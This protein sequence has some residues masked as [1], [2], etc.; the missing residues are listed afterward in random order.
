MQRDGGVVTTLL[1]DGRVLLTGAEC[2]RYG[3]QLYDP[4]TDVVSSA[5]VMAVPNGGGYTATLLG[6]GQVLFAGGYGGPRNTHSR[7][8]RVPRPAAPTTPT[9]TWVTAPLSARRRPP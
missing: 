8:H 1:A 3:P 9:T 4:Q 6:N 7:P 5:G 2:D